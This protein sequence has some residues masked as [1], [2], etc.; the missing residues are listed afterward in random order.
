MRDREF[1]QPMTRGERIR[2]WFY[3]PVHV[4]VLPIVLPFVIL[5]LQGRDIEVSSVQLNLVYYIIGFM[6]LGIALMSF[7]RES[8]SDFCDNFFSCVSR[9]LI[10]IM[11]YY[12]ASYVVNFV[13]GFFVTDL[14]NPNTGSV[15]DDVKDNAKPMLAVAVLLAPIV[16]EV[17]FRGIVFGSIV[18]KSRVLAYIVSTAAFSVYHLWQYALVGYEVKL[19][20]LYLIQYLPGSILL[21][22]CYE[23]SGSIWSSIFMHMT[24]NYLALLATQLV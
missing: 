18:S 24:V 6:F 15:I 17:L 9:I 3:L 4:F 23:D 2:G 7:L 12:A 16:E 10:G 1:S 8:F 21:A 11:L 19:L 5:L 22:K 13:L 20:L 14:V